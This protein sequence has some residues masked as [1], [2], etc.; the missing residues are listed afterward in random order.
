[1]RFGLGL[2]VPYSAVGVNSARYSEVGVNSTVSGEKEFLGSKVE[3][4]D[5]LDDPA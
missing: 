1:V 2:T 3:V 5:E 4:H